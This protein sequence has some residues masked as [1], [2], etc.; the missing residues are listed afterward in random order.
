MEDEIAR[1]T[2][3]NLGQDNDLTKF[4]E[5]AHTVSNPIGHNARTCLENKSYENLS[6][7]YKETEAAETS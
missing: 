2:R 7:D 3:K 1:K 6:S 4:T 5:F